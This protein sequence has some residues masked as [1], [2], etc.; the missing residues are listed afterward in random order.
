MCWHCCEC[1]TVRALESKRQTASGSRFTGDLLDDSVF[2][3]V[4]RGLAGDLL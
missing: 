4:W 1:N 2:G 3:G